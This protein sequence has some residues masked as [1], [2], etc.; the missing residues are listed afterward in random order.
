MRVDHLS[1]GISLSEMEV[2]VLY[3]PAVLLLVGLISNLLIRPV[4]PEHFTPP[5]RAG[6]TMQA[7]IVERPAKEHAL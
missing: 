6:D 2:E 5:P 7:N 1:D 3:L 4:S